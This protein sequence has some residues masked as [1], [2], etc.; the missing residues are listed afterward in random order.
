MAKGRPRDW[1]ILRTGGSSTLRLLHSLNVAGFEAWTPLECQVTRDRKSGARHERM[2]AV[3]PTYVFARADRLTDLLLISAEPYTCHPGFSVFKHFDRF[4]IVA[5]A[6]LAKLREVELKAAAKNEPVVFPRGQEVKVR[7][8]G[9]EGLT[10][11][12]AEISKGQWTLVA[13]PNFS[14]PIKFATWQLNAVDLQEPDS[15]AQAA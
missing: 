5:E 14:I 1:C 3:M 9:W 10:G 2:I 8:E 4:P 12:V 15:A 13:F 7:A 11:K 6:E